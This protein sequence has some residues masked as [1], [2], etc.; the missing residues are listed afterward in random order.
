MRTGSGYDSRLHSDV[1]FSRPSGPRFLCIDTYARNLI[2]SISFKWAF[3]T[4]LLPSQVSL[5]LQ[6]PIIKSGGYLVQNCEVAS[7]YR[8]LG[9]RTRPTPGT[10][11]TSPSRIWS[12]P[13]R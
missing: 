7:I 8:D 6:M 3:E 9:S 2:R 13:S 4:A 5:G 11:V 10:S 1:L 12:A